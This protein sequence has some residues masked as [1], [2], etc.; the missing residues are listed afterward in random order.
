MN[1]KTCKCG[2]EIGTNKNCTYCKQF[3]EEE[4]T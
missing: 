4:G 1:K 2:L 3:A